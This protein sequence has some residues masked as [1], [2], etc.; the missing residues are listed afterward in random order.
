MDV[1]KIYQYM[2]RYQSKVFNGACKIYLYFLVR[3]IVLGHRYRPPATRVTGMKVSDECVFQG[4]GDGH[5]LIHANETTADM[6]ISAIAVQVGVLM[7]RSFFVVPDDVVPNF[8]EQCIFA[9]EGG[10][11]MFVEHFSNCFVK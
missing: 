10:N 7:F 4:V 2:L 1:W 3:P 9:R 6:Q 8:F 11:Q 5:L